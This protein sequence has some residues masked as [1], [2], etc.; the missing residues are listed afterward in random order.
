VAGQDTRALVG[1][2]Y[3][4]YERRDFA[5]VSALLHDDVDWIIYAPIG[6]FPFAGP[7]KGRAAALEALGAIATHYQLESYK[8]LTIVIEGDRA[9]V[10]SDARF[11]QRTSNRT[12]R[13]HVVNFLRFHDGKV[14]EFREFANTFDMAEQAL[15]R[16]LAV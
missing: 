12:L 11:I 13:F 7:R 1:D 14:I 9:A 2:L 10:M 3:G 6:M 4:A 5:R 8:P 16:F 15:G